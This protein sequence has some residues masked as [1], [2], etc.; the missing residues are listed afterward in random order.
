MTLDVAGANTQASDISFLIGYA[1]TLANTDMSE[2]AVAGFSWGGISELF[3][4]AR[5]P[6]IK[7]LVALDG[8]MRYFPGITK[9]AGYVHPEDMTMP[10]LYFAQGEISLENIELH[11]SS[12][13]QTGPNPLN[14]WTHG[15]LI[16]VHDLALI[17][18]EHS[19]M[20]QRDESTWTHYSEVQKADY[21]REDGITGYAWV[22]RYTLHYL[23]AYLKHDT[24]AQDWLKKT[25][26]ENGAPAHFLSVSFRPE[27]GIPASLDSFRSELGR[28][29]FDHA[30]EIYAAM[31]KEKPEFQLDED[32]MNDW[33]SQLMQS[34]HLH[35]AIALLKLNL[36][37]YPESSNAYTILGEIYAKSGDKQL[38]RESYTKALEKN[39]QNAEARD[40]LQ[41]LDSPALASK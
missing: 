24:A 9:Q 27:N 13:I 17:H 6:R 22:A 23:N 34:S 3:A 20:F 5:D 8:S 11:H 35:E 36:Q 33:G 14:A 40:K 25:P 41:E 32:A 7:A 39:S 2:V 18:T 26:A 15:D 19:S 31:K 1:Q 28:Q 30:A 4:A 12:P 29:G 21:T 37:N 38:A 16:T 10:L